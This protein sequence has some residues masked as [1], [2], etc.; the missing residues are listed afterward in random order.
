[1]VAK[2]VHSG[3]GGNRTQFDGREDGQ[4]LR[5]LLHFSQ[6]AYLVRSS[7][8][9]QRDKVGE[10]GFDNAK[11]LLEGTARHK[12]YEMRRQTIKLGDRSKIGGGGWTKDPGVREHTYFIVLRATALE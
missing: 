9:Q 12:S 8:A 3:K 10:R 7:T 6:K 5:I 4:R 11:Q 2:R 1:M